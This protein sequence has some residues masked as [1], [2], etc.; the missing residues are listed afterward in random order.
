MIDPA[1]V[2]P[3][4]AVDRSPWLVASSVWVLAGFV[5]PFLTPA[6]EQ[7][8]A[9]LQRTLSSTAGMSGELAHRVAFT[10]VRI[11][12]T[13]M[14]AVL[15]A[16]VQCAVASGVRPLARRW[17][18][19]A[20]LGGC[21]ATLIYLPSTLVALQIWGD[22]SGATVRRLLFVTGAGLLAGL[23]SFLQRRRARAQVVVPSW[24]VVASVLAAAV[25]YFASIELW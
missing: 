18:V 23:V 12:L 3:S 2:E 15:V 16:T 6:T 19:A 7:L 14:L 20:A 17:I 25:G 22:I 10:I 8:S 5:F 11:P 1:P 9:G 24:F 21:I 13:A 4:A